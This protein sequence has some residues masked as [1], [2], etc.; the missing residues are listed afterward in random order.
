LHRRGYL[1]QGIH[2]ASVVPDLV[3]VR[4]LPT[5]KP[6]SPSH[7]KASHAATNE[8]ILRL[9]EPLLARPLRILDL[10]CGSG[11]FLNKLAGL[12]QQRGWA[13]EPNLLGVDID[14]TH[15][16]ASPVPA[17]QV[18]VNQAL[19]LADASFDVVLAIEVFEHTRAPYLLLQDVFRILA[20]GGHL[21]LSVPNVMH[22]LSRLSYLF[23]GHY[24]MYPTPSARGENAGRLCGHIEPLPLQYW[25]YGLR[26][27]GFGEIAYEID[28]AKKGALAPAL[29]FAPLIMAANAFY[30]RRMKNYDRAVADETRHVL[31]HVNSLRTLTARSLLFS[32]RKPA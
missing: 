18:D 24:Y 31:R 9:V 22:I 4:H 28:R 14:L 20:P 25:D 30:Q 11:Y 5:A 19:P 2:A 29:L 1:A 13:I 6:P 27:A 32:A 16:R 8:R 21:V 23:T 3:Q 17:K 15:Y 10:G 12:Y 7:E 26:Y